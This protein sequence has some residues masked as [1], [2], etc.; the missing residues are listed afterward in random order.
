MKYPPAARDEDASTCFVFDAGVE[1]GRELAQ[2][3]VAQ[4]VQRLGAVERD[5]LHRP[6]AVSVSAVATVARDTD[7]NTVS[8]RDTS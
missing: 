1:D 5:D 6:E 4:R 2:Q 7:G 8:P 3:L